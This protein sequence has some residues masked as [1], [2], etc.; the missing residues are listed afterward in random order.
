ML[1]D[2]VTSALDMETEEQLLKNLSDRAHEHGQT[3]IFITH[4]KGVLNLCTG[5]LDL[6][7]IPDNTQS[8]VQ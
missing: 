8:E 6:S 5:V 3:V 1:L 2:E 4:R 7:E